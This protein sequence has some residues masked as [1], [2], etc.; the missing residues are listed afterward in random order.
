MKSRAALGSH[1]IHPMLVPI[2]IGAF[3]IALVA[4][5]MF[6]LKPEHRFWYD[7][8][9]L[10]I[11]IGIGFALLSAIF[12]VVDY[13][14]VRMSSRALK[15][16]TWHGGLNL[17]MVALYATSFWLRRGGAAMLPTRWPAALTLSA[18][19]F[20]L[21]VVTGW[22]GGK[23]VYEHHVAVSERPM[24]IAGRAEPERAVS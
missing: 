7:V 15:T 20:L 13:F 19:G 14:G 3:L 12:G 2:P 11:P 17:L 8:G 5:V 9:F 10:C 18:T 21:V 4:D 23:L 6:T 22:L 24:R 1:P 16:A